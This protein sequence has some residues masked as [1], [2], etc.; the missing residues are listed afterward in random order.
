MKALVTLSRYGDSMN[1]MAISS[2]RRTGPMRRRLRFVRC[3]H[4]ASAR[5]PDVNQLLE[6]FA[7]AVRSSTHRSA[8]HRRNGTS[9]PSH[10]SDSSTRRSGIGGTRAKSAVSGW[11][12]KFRRV[13]G[14]PR[15]QSSH[16]P[17]PGMPVR[18]GPAGQGDLQADQLRPRRVHVAT[19]F[20]EP[21]GERQPGRV[22]VR[23]FADRAEERGFV[24]HGVAHAGFE[25]A[26]AV[27]SVIL[28]RPTGSR[29]CSPSLD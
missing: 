26:G 18:A 8:G 24:T 29:S 16:E 1:A 4:A 23:L 21:V 7:H 19:L 14:K 2:D 9:S 3:G 25:G 13:S 12:S 11:I 5:A 10:E 27:T 28:P 20:R 17:T 6:R 22:L 15:T